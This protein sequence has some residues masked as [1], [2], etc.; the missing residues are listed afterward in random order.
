MKICVCALLFFL[1]LTANCLAGSLIPNPLSV[2]SGKGS[3]SL[4]NGDSISFP[5]GDAKAEFVAQNFL[6]LVANTYGLKLVKRE[7]TLGST[8]SISRCSIS[9][10]KSEEAYELTV[11]KDGI[12]IC[13][14]GDAG[15]YYASATLWQMMEKRAAIEVD[16]THIQDAPRFPW[17]G[18]LLDSARHYQS[19]EFIRKLINVLSLYKIN[20][21]HWHL[22]DD[23]AWRLEIKQYPRLTDFAAWRVP[24]GLG[25]ENDIDPATGKPRL[26]GGFYSQEQV[27]E[28]VQYASERNVTI[29]PEIE[30]PGHAAAAIVAYPEFGSIANPPTA[31]PH[32]WGVFPYLYNVGDD[33]FRFLEN[34]LDEVMSL[35]PGQFI[36]VGGD[37]AIKDQ[38]KASAQA[39]QA[40][41]QL[42][43]K[44]EDELQA[45]FIQRVGQYVESHGK[46]II[47]WDDILSP[48]LSQPS[49]VMSW[50]G[51]DG[52]IKGAKSGH[53]VVVTAAPNF[54]FDGR[55]NESSDQP[56][57]VAD[58]IV[59]LETAFSFNPMPT[60]LT[61][62]QQKHI[63]GVEGAVWTEDFNTDEQI[64][65][66]TFPRELAIAEIGW[67]TVKS[68]D[69]NN[70]LS[71][72]P[73]AQENLAL[74][75]MEFSDSP[76]E[77]IIEHI[78]NKNRETVSVSIS[79]QTNFGEL[80]Y[81]LDGKDPAT[82]SKPFDAAL[83]LPIGSTLRVASFFKG[84]RISRIK[85]KNFDIV[86]LHT[87]NSF[88]LKSCYPGQYNLATEDDAFT[89]GKK[90]FFLVDYMH[91]CWIYENADLSDSV[92]LQ[93]EVG[94]LPFNLQIGDDVNSIHYRKPSTP[95][96]ELEVRLDN[97][98]GIRVASIPLKSAVSNPGVSA[99]PPTTLPA[100]FGVHN[101][102]FTFT[103]SNI[104]PYWVINKVQLLP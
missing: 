39:Q 25:P 59:S 55:M 96:G 21:L 35:F 52:A 43:L 1:A 62:D 85:Q 54:Y 12:R 33:S 41:K 92:T 72:I 77:P 68:R 42:G 44:N 66:T 3:F 17:R 51:L 53:D 83:N 81:T 61:A 79:N 28:L 65:L 11:N 99:L 67:S 58:N 9:F 5:K 13:A 97:C 56:P 95:E 98:F 38:W 27:K 18:M 24:A 82:D 103:Q 31:I 49:A 46:R 104:D 45:W 32:D 74:L 88:E 34:V 4:H 23:Q 89:N 7:Q 100:L 16:F 70:F 30:M 94:Q 73:S 101:L 48:R 75:G 50:H 78:E 26:Y 2:L 29:V 87:R 90:A 102:C 84:K 63:L 36:H 80:R 19:P 20:R 71:R 91:P 93:A 40:I 37:E 57:G 8:I 14:V 47:G 64:A 69:W 86:S 15:I 60:A 6:D 22:T 10:S 76:F